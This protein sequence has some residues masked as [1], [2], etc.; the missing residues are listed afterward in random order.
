MALNDNLRRMAPSKQQA[1]RFT[2]PP[3]PLVFPPAFVRRFPELDGVNEQLS[4]WHAEAQQAITDFIES[5][6]NSE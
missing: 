4:A 3:L 5:S 1:R 6:Q 2:L